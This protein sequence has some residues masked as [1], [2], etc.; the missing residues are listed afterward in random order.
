MR[1]G[2]TKRKSE[3]KVEVEETW[4]FDWHTSSFDLPHIT[5][6]DMHGSSGLL[7][8]AQICFRRLLCHQVHR[9]NLPIVV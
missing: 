2:N 1:E 9:N 5:A 3:R 7:I 6:S 4:D 8:M